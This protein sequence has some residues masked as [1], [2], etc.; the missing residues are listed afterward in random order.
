MT[1]RCK[2]ALIVLLVT[3]LLNQAAAVDSS[4]TRLFDEASLPSDGLT[5]SAVHFEQQNVFDLNERG[6]FWLHRF[7]NYSHVVSKQLTISND[8][9]FAPQSPLDLAELAE[10]ERILRGRSYIR[11]ADVT[12]SLY[13][14]ESNTVEV[15]VKTWDNWSLLPKI[16]FSSEGGSTEY[17]IGI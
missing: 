14:P 4:C 17:S 15:L 13:C 12:V 8:L 3:T 5:I 10:T 2:A 6:T 9:L 11:D 7:A 16:D 1:Y